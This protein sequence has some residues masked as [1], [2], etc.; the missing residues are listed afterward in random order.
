MPYPYGRRL[1][2]LAEAHIDHIVS[3]KRGSNKLSDL[4]TFCRM[5]HL[6]CADGPHRGMIARAL[7]AG[8]IRANRWDMVWE[9]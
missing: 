9:G 3:G 6:L 8:V 5:R 4:R 7:R 1:V 2:A